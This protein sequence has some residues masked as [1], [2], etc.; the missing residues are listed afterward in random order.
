MLKRFGVSLEDDLL[1]QFD[2]LIEE[3]GYT[4]RSEAIRDLIRDRLVKEEWVDEEKETAGAVLIVY[5]HHQYEL[6]QKMTDAQHK[7][8]DSIISSLH[9]HL[10]H[11]NCLEIVV[12]RG[13]ARVIKE[14]ADRI[15]ST[16]G[17]KF[18]QFMN[19]TSGKNF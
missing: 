4:N 7:H 19:A 1:I 5:D 16:K 14:I 12:L 17:V 10:D 11:H 9:V 18:G 15:I 6:A 13:K 8:V 2:K 3:K